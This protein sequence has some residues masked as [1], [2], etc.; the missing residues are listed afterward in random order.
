M[1]IAIDRNALLIRHRGG[2]KQNIGR[3]VCFLRKHSACIGG[4]LI[5]S[6]WAT[7]CTPHGMTLN[8][9]LLANATHRHLTVPACVSISIYVQPSSK[10]RRDAI[11]SIYGDPT[12]WHVKTGQQTNSWST[13]AVIDGSTSDCERLMQIVLQNALLCIVK[14]PWKGPLIIIV[15]LVFDWPKEC[16]LGDIMLT[17]ALIKFLFYY[18]PQGTQEHSVSYN[19]TV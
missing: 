9:L 18:N 8:G 1:E 17:V 7:K 4:P 11:C 15:Q 3:S 2:S 12:N 16:F 14:Q 19:Y 6:S 13:V 10:K 5:S